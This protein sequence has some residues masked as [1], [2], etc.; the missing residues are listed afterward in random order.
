MTTSPEDVLS[1]F[2]ALSPGD[3]E[4]LSLVVWE[5][6]TPAEAAQVLSIPVARFSVRLHRARRRL[7]NRL[8]AAELPR[9]NPITEAR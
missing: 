3:Q 5:E 8:A 9:N 4:V 6:L 1:A 2:H 7:L